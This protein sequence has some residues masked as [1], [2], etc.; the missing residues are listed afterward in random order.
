MFETHMYSF[1]SKVYQQSGGGPI[2]LR[3]T[4]AIAKIVLSEWDLKL[5]KILADNEVTT[6]EAARYIDD[7]RIMLKAINPGWRWDGKTIVFREDNKTQQLEM[8]V[9]A[10]L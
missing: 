4:G 3:A 5:M 2:G 10:A 7:V 6:E 9:A 1:G 8:T